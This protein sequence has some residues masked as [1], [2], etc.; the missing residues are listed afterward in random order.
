MANYKSIYTGEEI[1]AGIAKANTAI[2]PEDLGGLAEKDTVDYETEVTNKPTIPSEATEQ[3][4]ANW[5][6]TK[7]T[8]NYSKPSTGIPEEDLSEDVQ[9]KLNSGGGGGTTV[10][11]NPILDGTESHLDGLKVGNTKYS[12]RPDLS[13]KVI[14]IMGDS[15][16]TYADWI[17]NSRG[18][19]DGT[20]TLKHAVYYPNYGA[21]LSNVNM[22]WWYK[23][24]FDKI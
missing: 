11:A 21:Y 6:F 7:N 1:D 18:I 20:G 10:Q 8:G 14:S 12:T 15:I 17:P 22:T 16:S 24:I 3:T 4:V 2:Q 5:G 19:D 23:L 9:D 13:G